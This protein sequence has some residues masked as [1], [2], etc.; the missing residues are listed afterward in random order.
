MQRIIQKWVDLFVLNLST[1]PEVIVHVARE[2]GA[3][4]VWSLQTGRLVIRLLSK[5][6]LEPLLVV[7][8]DLLAFG[9]Q[10]AGE[11]LD[12][13]QRSASER[14][15]NQDLTCWS[16]LIFVLFKNV[17][18]SFVKKRDTMCPVNYLW[19]SESLISGF[20]LQFSPSFS[21]LLS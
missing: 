21:L 3:V 10:E 13:S 17:K 18:G 4:I 20:I 9:L 11:C 2:D 12:D 19:S 5:L 16:P 7:D 14:D 1:Y 6:F 8:H 15:E